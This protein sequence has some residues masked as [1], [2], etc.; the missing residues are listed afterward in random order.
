MSHVMESSV[1]CGTTDEHEL[2][3]MSK[4]GETRAIGDG[5]VWGVSSGAR[6][7]INNGY[8]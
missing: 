6:R 1:C 7:L 8:I 4:S 5:E 3:A 2:H